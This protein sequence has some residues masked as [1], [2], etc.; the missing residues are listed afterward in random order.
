MRLS[1]WIL[2]AMAFAPSYIEAK[3]VVFWQPG[4]P[5]IASAPVDA[6]SLMKALGTLAPNADSQPFLADASR[7]SAESTLAGANLL[8]LPYGSAFPADAWKSI[9]AYLAAGGN[10]LILGGQPMRVPV[11]WLA[12]TYVAQREQDTYS[13]AIGFRHTYEVPVGRDAAFH[14]KA[15]YDWLPDLKI[16]ARRFFTLEGRLD[17]LGYMTGPSGELIAAPVVVA[18]SWN[19][20]EHRMTGG[21]IVALDF[22]PEPGFWKSGDGLQ[23]IYQAALYAIQGSAEFSVETQYSDM[24]PGEQTQ[25]TVHWHSP[26]EERLDNTTK[27]EVRMTLKSGEKTVAATAIPIDAKGRADADSTLHLQLPLGFYDLSAVYFEDG[28]AREFYRNGFFVTDHS[29]IA[30]GPA[31]GVHGDFLSLEGK[32]FLPVGTN[33]FTTEENGWDFSGPRNAWVWEKDFADMEAHGVSFVRTGVWMNNAK[34]IDPATGGANERFLRNIEAFLLCAQRHHIAVNFTFFAFSPRS[35]VQ[36][37][38]P[39]SGTGDTTQPN[40]YLGPMAVAAQQAYVRSVAERFKDVPWLSWDLINEPS[41]SNPKHIFSGNYPNGDPAETTEWHNWLRKNYGTLEKLSDA[42]SVP[43]NSLGSFDA[44][45][46]VS[47][48]DMHYDRNRNPNQIRALDYNLFA[49]DMFIGWVKG[50]VATIRA[51]SPTQ[52]INVGQDEGGVTD[53]VLN[54]FYGGAGVSFTTNHTYWQDDALLWDSV[55]AKRPGVPN[56]TGETGYQPAWSS[57]GA[58]R[59]DEFTGLGLTERKWAL[60]FA[61]GSSGA[62]QWDWAREVDFGMQRSDG[63]ARVWEGMMRDLG[64]FARQAAPYADKF[65]QPGVAIV[66][67]QSYQMSVSN[68][69][70]LEAQKAAVRTLYNYAHGQGYAIGEYQTELL[71]SPKLILLP[72]PYGLTDSAWQAIEKRVREGAVLLVTGPFGEDAHFHATN[73]QQAAGLPYTLAP[74]TLRDSVLHFPGGDERLAFSGNKTTALNRAE[75]PGGKDWVEKPFGKGSILFSALPVELNDNLQAVADV[76]SYAMKLAGVAAAYTTTSGDP[77]ILICPSE[78]S[79]ATLYVLAS[80]SNRE[81]VSF[82]DARSG[83]SFTGNLPA[84]RAALLLIGTDGKLLASYHW[85][86]TQ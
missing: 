82:T 5:T 45:P 16:R 4:F 26:R 37:E 63:S 50:M 44:I 84:G 77:G 48:A 49:Q 76:Y 29:A 11:Q 73:R 38:S 53:R 28:K 6:E 68:S 81:Q 10:L 83:K 78:Y 30:S 40:P 18:N 2:L 21:R 14:W 13:R 1:A 22:D 9:D 57:D 58:W 34:F 71:G 64:A 39:Q 86:S 17:G 52:L 69:F 7:L 12:G 80:E 56:I 60:G 47:I 85:P 72:S 79:N 54:Q 31:L 27:G 59:Y 23:L 33:Y 24:R 32:P 20:A 65:I 67:P 43:V 19:V 74:L 75:L 41:F 25:I 70:A 55:A 46:L 8:V 15:G 62:M 51:S 3:V 35:G 61:A 42:W 36:P 66:L